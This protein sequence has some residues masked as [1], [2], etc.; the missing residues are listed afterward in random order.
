LH[1]SF[2]FPLQVATPD[3]YQTQLFSGSPLLRIVGLGF[4]DHK[5]LL[6]GNRLSS[7][8][9]DTFKPS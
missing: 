1:I 6:L 4:F 7:M 5:Q 3:V 8:P 2:N 9:Y